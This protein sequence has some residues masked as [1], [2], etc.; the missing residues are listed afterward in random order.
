MVTIQTD[1]TDTFL[2][3]LHYQ[4]SGLN[5]CNKY[6]CFKGV[7]ALAYCSHICIQIRLPNF[8][9]KMVKFLAVDS[10]LKEALLL[11]LLLECL[12]DSTETET[13]WKRISFYK[14]RSGCLEP[15]WKYF[16]I[17]WKDESKSI[18]IALGWWAKNEKVTFSM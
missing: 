12:Y 8:N 5:R 6:W 4:P 9:K 10:D 16:S 11:N 15:N 3:I 13:Y 14:V 2:N 1:D 18:I 7:F 17:H